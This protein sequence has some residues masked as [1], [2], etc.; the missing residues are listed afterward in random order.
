MWGRYGNRG[1]AME[2]RRKGDKGKK[3]MQERKK[4]S[5]VKCF[6]VKRRKVASRSNDGRMNKS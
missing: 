2:Q 6:D 1:N 4:K 5:V 3:G